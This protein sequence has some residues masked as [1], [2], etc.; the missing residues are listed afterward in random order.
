MNR[1][2]GVALLAGL[3]AACNSGDSFL[4]WDEETAARLAAEEAAAEAAAERGKMTD[5][6]ILAAQAW[7]ASNEGIF[8]EPASAASVAG[9]MK[10]LSGSPCATCPLASVLR[11]GSRIVLTVTGHGLK[12]TETPV[13]FGGFIPKEAEANLDAVR[14]V[15]EKD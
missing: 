12:D 9:L 14:A 11:T 15:L 1:I 4:E 10:C 6:E 2:L 3:L 8:V 5:E 7:L 13:A